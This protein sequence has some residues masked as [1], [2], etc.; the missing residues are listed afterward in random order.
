MIIPPNNH[1][2]CIY[3]KSGELIVELKFFMST[4][5]NGEPCLYVKKCKTLKKL[6]T[7][8]RRFIDKPIELYDKN[9]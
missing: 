1:E 3:I 2:K 7:Y 4:I 9:D 8:A 6:K 5:P